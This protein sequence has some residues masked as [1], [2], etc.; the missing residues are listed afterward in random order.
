[1]GTGGLL[2]LA[3]VLAARL[4]VTPPPVAALRNDKIGA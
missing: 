3:T 1:M 2:F 4:P